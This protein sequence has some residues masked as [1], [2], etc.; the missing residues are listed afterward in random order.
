MSIDVQ[1]CY[2]QEVIKISRVHSVPGLPVRTLDIYGEDFRAVDQVLMNQVPTSS[3]VVL[4]KT[5]MLVEVPSPLKNMTITSI[6]VL[7]RRLLI[8]PRS[9]IQFR[10]GTTASKTRGILRLMQL[11][12]KML[13]T[14]PGTDIFAPKVGGGAMV[15]LG[16]T[17]SSDKTTNV[18]SDLVISVNNTSQQIIQIQG[19]NQSL[20][21]DERL[22]SAK[23]LSAGFNRNET[24]IVASIEVL[25][26]AG[27]VGLAQLNL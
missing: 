9:F 8:T 22:A 19:R 10:I 1:F 18:V 20:P 26:H 11:F 17:V 7:S 2:P 27:R 6:M 4:S 16:Q 3:F 12:L 23:L 13:L 14:T 5:R 21:P 24:A 15:H 25:S